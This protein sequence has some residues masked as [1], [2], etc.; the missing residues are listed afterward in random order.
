MLRLY[1]LVSKPCPGAD[2][3]WRQ[4]YAAGP[5]EVSTHPLLERVDLRFIRADRTECLSLRQEYLRDI[6]HER[7]R[8]AFVAADKAV[9]PHLRRIQPSLRECRIKLWTHRQLD[10][11]PREGVE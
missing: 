11:G 5:G 1:A 6:G 8:D 4:H 7:R 9:D 2:Q 3:E 10:S